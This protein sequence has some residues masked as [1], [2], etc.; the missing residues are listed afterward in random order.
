MKHFFIPTA[1]NGYR[2]YLLRTPALVLFL[3]VIYL[4]NS[5]VGL[6]PV[7]QVRAEINIEQ[8]LDQHNVERKKFNL[9]PLKVNTA[10]NNSAQQKAVAMLRADCWSHYCPDGQSPWDFFGEAGY[11]YIYAGENLAEGFFDTDA[12]VVA[13]MNSPTHRE[14]M[15]RPEFEDVGFGIVQGKFQGLENNVIIV[16]HFATPQPPVP[17]NVAV[18]ELDALPTP[19]ITKPRYGS[20]IG[21]NEVEIE[22]TAPEAS[23]VRIK[24][25]GVP[26]VTTDANQGIFTVKVQGLF[27]ARYQITATSEIGTRVSAESDPVTFV[28]DTSP[29]VI[30]IDKI[31]PIS[32]QQDE[33]ILQINAPSLSELSLVIG[34]TELDPQ[35]V[36]ESI[37]EV[38]LTAGQLVG[39]SI[40]VSNRDLAGN[41]WSGDLSGNEIYAQL[42]LLPGFLVATPPATAIP[43]FTKASVNVVFVLLMMGLFVLDFLR[44][45]RSG[46][47]VKGRGRSHLHVTVL[48]VI[49]L[50]ALTGAISGDIATGLTS[51]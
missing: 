17:E 25:N 2:A 15:L 49:A 21:T 11:N 24:N 50:I 35:R 14:N 40:T 43:V 1:E 44:V 7:A 3:I 26:L 20:N 8:L 37:W 22:G 18:L 45:E 4:A 48:I 41:F 32:A 28:I 19:E 34:Q 9:P 36:T 29:D 47:T 6:F 13:W 33:V 30:T 27:D 46:M 12:A 42:D 16:V 31:V 39:Q 51:F 10:L 38:K 5:I 23:Q